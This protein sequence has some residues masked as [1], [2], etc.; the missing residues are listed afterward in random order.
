M[1][2]LDTLE[3]LRRSGRLSNFRAL[4]G[5]LLKVK[6]LLT[7]NDDIIGMERVRTRQKALAWLIDQ[8]ERLGPLQQLMLVHTHAPEAIAAFGEEIQHLAPDSDPLMAVDVTP[9]LGAHLGPG[10]VGFTCIT[11]SNAPGTG[12]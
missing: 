7:M 6:P 10:V 8:L 12:T 11:S 9:V 4:M 5:T 1:A 3:Y 2:A